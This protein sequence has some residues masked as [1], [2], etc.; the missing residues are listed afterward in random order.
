MWWFCCGSAAPQEREASV[1]VLQLAVLDLSAPDGQGGGTNSKQPEK[2]LWVP[3]PHHLEPS[4]H[5]SVMTLLPQPP[6]DDLKKPPPS[7]VFTKT[8]NVFRSC[9]SETSGSKS[10]SMWAWPLE[11]RPLPPLS[12]RSNMSAELDRRGGG[13]HKCQDWQSLFSTVSV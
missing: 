9:F 12:A 8:L 11:L 10:S 1:F 13:G 4:E 5:G 7:G 3:D 6:H 2:F